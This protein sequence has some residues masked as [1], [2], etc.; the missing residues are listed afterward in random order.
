MKLTRGFKNADRY[1]FDFDICRGWQQWDHESDASYYGNWLNID[2]LASISYVE[3]DIC[4]R[5]FEDIA[6]F[7]EYVKKEFERKIGF[8]HIDV[9]IGKNR[10][11]LLGKY[12]EA[13]LKEYTV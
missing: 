13:G 11:E 4:K 3:G 2:K 10:D 7:A 8:K 9:G 1:V 12:Q 6:E 5:E